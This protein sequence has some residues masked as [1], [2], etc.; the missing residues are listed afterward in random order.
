MKR[1][2]NQIF[3]FLLL[4]SFVGCSQK[5]IVIKKELVCIQQQ[6]VPKLKEIGIHFLA[7]KKSDKKY[8][9]KINLIKK[10]IVLIKTKKEAIKETERFYENQVDR[11]NLRCEKVKIK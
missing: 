1:L 5:E 6:K 9:E 10:Q 8:K 3:I 2:M 11:N 7:P 4:F